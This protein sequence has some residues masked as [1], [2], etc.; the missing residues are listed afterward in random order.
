M[1]FSDSASLDIGKA[2]NNICDY[3]DT[4]YAAFWKDHDRE[5]EDEVER[6]AL[7]RLTIDMTDT[8]IDIGGGYGRLVN[9]YAPRCTRVLLTDYAENMVSQ[10]RERVAQLGLNNVDCMQADLYQLRKYGQK[11]KNAVCVRVMHHV[12]NVPD[13]FTQ[14]NMI[15]EEGGT[16]ILEYANKK[17]IV[18]ILRY[19]FRRAN[20]APFDYLPSKRP[21][22]IYYNFHPRYIKDMLTQHGFRIEEELAVS[23]FRNKHLKK[24][25]GH[26]ILSRL[27]ARLQ[28]VLGRFHPS[29]SVFIKARKVGDC[30]LDGVTE[31]SQKQRIC[32]QFRLIRRYIF[33]K[34]AHRP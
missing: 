6:I 8:C 12:E 9:E 16:F 26:R 27:E 1:N 20:I 21:S 33:H 31:I 10:A 18:E 5:Y 17:N 4:D 14:V 11:F 30:G 22:N 13:F 32:C 24:I 28:K 2:E 7:R 34:T 3:S 19:I 25:V 29:P 15:L 23:I